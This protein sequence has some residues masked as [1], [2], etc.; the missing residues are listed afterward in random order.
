MHLI[1]SYIL[2]PLF[3][4]KGVV[5]VVIRESENAY[6]TQSKKNQSPQAKSIDERRLL[7]MKNLAGITVP[8]KCFGFPASNPIFINDQN[9]PAEELQ[10]G[11]VN[12]FV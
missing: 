1:W 9:E 10:G 6:T 5:R 3:P 2:E 7:S 11:E 4:P 12:K 8:V